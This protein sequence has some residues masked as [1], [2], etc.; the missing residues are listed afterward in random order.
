MT[1]NQFNELR[2]YR[3]AEGSCIS[4]WDDHRPLLSLRTN[5]WLK[6]VVKDCWGITD[7]GVAAFDAV[8]DGSANLTI[9]REYE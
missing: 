4:D 3:E 5:G 6:E 1:E 8:I 7:K 9:S 2:R